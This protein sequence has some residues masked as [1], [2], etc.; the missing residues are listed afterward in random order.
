MQ[1][2]ERNKMFK[3][4]A[5]KAITNKQD[6]NVL[7]LIL[8]AVALFAALSYAVTSSTRSSSNDAGSGTNLISSA[9]ITQY[10]AGISA[11]VVRM[12]IAGTSPTEIRFNRPAEFSTLDYDELG[13]F[14][15]NG[16]AASYIPAPANVMVNGNPGQWV[17]NAELEIP[18]IGLDGAGGND[19][20]AYLIG[21]KQAICSKI[22]D[23]HGLGTAIPVLNADRSG[24]YTRRM[25]DD[26]VSDYTV[27]SVDV[28]DI[29]DNSNSFDGQP[30]GCFQN[31]GGGDYVYYHVVIER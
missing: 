2:F 16:G 31:L 11:A 6:G 26:G 9:Q 3:V 18:Q 10:P 13:V 19:I 30:F 24:Q 21:I 20:I 14:H 1:V 25:Y 15:P 5:A 7:F 29:S 12:I 17:F 8:I 22:N 28:P 23:E 4:N 27:P